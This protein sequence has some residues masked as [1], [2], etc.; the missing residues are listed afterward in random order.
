MTNPRALQL[1]KEANDLWFLQGFT[2]Q[3]LKAYQTAV[4]EDPTDPI[5]LYQLARALWA[6][7][8][9]DEAR[10]KLA[11]AQHYTNRLSPLGIKLL[12]EEVHKLS[13]PPSFR[14]LL[15]VAPYELDVEQIKVKVLSSNQWLDVANGAREREMFGVAAYA[16]SRVS[17]PFRIV[18]LDEDEREME[19]E[20]QK[21]LNMLYVMRPKGERE[22]NQ[23][24]KA[25]SPGSEVTRPTAP[26]LPTKMPRSSAPL[27]TRSFASPPAETGQHG[28]ALEISVIPQKSGIKEGL[29][30][31]VVLTND[32]DRDMA[33]N[34]RLLLN[35]PNSPPGYGEIF[36]HVEGPA[37]YQNMVRYHIRTGL[38]QSD[39]FALLPPRQSIEKTYELLNYESFH[40]PGVYR[41]WVTYR[42][43]ITD[44]VKGVPL[45]V[46]EL[47]SQA[48]S[49]ERV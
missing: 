6:L 17:R 37:G 20:A 9:L 10:E 40:L 12:A 16:F 42:N 13:N 36:L 31:R 35:R 32:S 2:N 15:P 41:V 21:A 39:Q 1:F 5:V 25:A 19:H 18:E 49:I 24:F 44:T 26:S 33:V 47:S 4:S 28:L 48:V 34:K 22:E 11:Q 27:P 8:R 43:T 38:P 46:G 14:F 29:S 7:S 45:F 23:P 3:S 30:L